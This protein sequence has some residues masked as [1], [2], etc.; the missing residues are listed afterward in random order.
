MTTLIIAGW[1]L[2]A[3]GAFGYACTQPRRLE[4]AW[5]ELPSHWQ[6]KTRTVVWTYHLPDGRSW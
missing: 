5:D 4:D 2:F 6:P 1:L 3:L